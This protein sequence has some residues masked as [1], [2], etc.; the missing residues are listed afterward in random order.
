MEFC[1][2][3]PIKWL[4]VFGHMSKTHLVLAQELKHKE[5]LEFYRKK[6][7]EHNVVILD[8]GAYEKDRVDFHQLVEC[9]KMLSPTYYV[10]PDEP[11]TFDQSGMM[12]MDFVKFSKPHGLAA[13]RL[14][15][16]HAEDGNTNNFVK[17][18]EMGCMWADGVCFSRLTNDY[19]FGKN[20]VRR[21]HFIQYLKKHNKWRLDK[22][23]HALGMLDGSLGELT[24]LA[25]EGVHSID[26]SAPIWR[27]LMG[28]KL[29][30]AKMWPDFKFVANYQGII[31]SA[32]VENSNESS[33][34]VWARQNLERVK[35]LCQS[36]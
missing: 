21:A 15:V 14:W 29:G 22:Y 20:E 1:P 32:P 27:G 26:S 6:V 24:L 36:K 12:G 7:D 31:S 13:K 3:I 8:N 2:I 30:N 16:V 17:S 10:M 35:E 5:Y 28:Y 34:I 19:G 4:D 25:R 33:G 9:I 23:V 18:Y 11:N